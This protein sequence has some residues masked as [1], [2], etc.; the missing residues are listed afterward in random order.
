MKEVR[1]M[2]EYWIT[3]AAAEIV[4]TL[5]WI[6]G[7]VDWGPVGWA[8]GLAVLPTFVAAGLVAGQIIFE[9][10]GGK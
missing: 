7:K 6:G 1:R 10:M 2:T 8:V 9:L 5:V 4:W 3:V